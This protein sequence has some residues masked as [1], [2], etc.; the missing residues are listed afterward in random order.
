MEKKS[1]QN[2]STRYRLQNATIAF[3]CLY[4][5]QSYKILRYARHLPH[6]AFNSKWSGTLLVPVSEALPEIPRGAS[7]FNLCSKTDW[8]QVDLLSIMFR[9]LAPFGFSGWPSETASRSGPDH[10]EK[11]TDLNRQPQ[12]FWLALVILVKVI[13]VWELTIF[14]GN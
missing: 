1:G 14:P 8:R 2:K 3:N 9:R 12:N 13:S 10:S 6:S 7:R 4:I 5:F 11:K